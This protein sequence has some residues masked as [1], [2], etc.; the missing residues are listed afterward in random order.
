M[1]NIQWTLLPAL[2]ADSE[3]EQEDLPTVGLDEPMWDEELVPDSRGYLCIHEIPR[4]A[5]PHP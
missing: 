3:N 5:T 1:T 4:L 2:A